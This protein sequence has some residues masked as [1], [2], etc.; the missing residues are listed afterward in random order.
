VNGHLLE[1]H[2]SGRVRMLAITT[3]A[4]IGAAPNIPTAVESGWPGVIAQNFYGLFAPVGTPKAI[5]EQISQATQIAMADN[6]FRQRY[7]A[8]GFEP[9][10]DSNPQAAQHF[11]EDEIARWAPVIKAIG[12]K[13]D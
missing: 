12:L 7:I 6:E 13:L 9:H 10:L 4:R 5:I 11:I 8:S 2:R 3:P 1:L